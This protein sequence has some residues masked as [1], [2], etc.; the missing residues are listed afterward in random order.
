MICALQYCK[1]ETMEF[2]TYDMYYRTSSN[3]FLCSHL[4]LLLVRTWSACRLLI[5]VDVEPDGS[6]GLQVQPLLEQL[7]DGHDG[8][9]LRGV[10]QPDGDLVHLHPDIYNSSVHLERQYTENLIS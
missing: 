5:L 9:G 7:P 1:N 6:G 4:K 8:L 2:K 10:R 3:F